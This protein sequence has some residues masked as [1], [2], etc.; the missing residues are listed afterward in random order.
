MNDHRFN[1]LKHIARNL[2]AMK[3]SEGNSIPEAMSDR[4]IMEIWDAMSGADD[5]DIID[6]I[7][8]DLID[9][10]IEAIKAAFPSTNG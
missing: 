1:A 3:S 6:C 4:L 10:K 2:R 8:G 7:V 9:D 5:Q